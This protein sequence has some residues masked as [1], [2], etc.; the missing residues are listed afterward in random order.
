MSPKPPPRPPRPPKTSSKSPA[1]AVA[2]EAELA[3]LIVL[4]TLFLVRQDGVGFLN[5]FE[6]FFRSVIIRVA[7]RMMLACEGAIRFLDLRLACV[8][9]DAQN[10][11]IVLGLRHIGCDTPD[12]RSTRVRK[13]SDAGGLPDWPR[14]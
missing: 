14:A 4:L 7:V 10:V 5:F 6:A 1:K 2:V 13:G 11:V 9:A 12:E 3:P 8:L